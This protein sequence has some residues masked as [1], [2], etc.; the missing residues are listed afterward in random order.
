V[1]SVI[2]VPNIEKALEI[3][4][5][6]PY[7]NA[8]SVYTTS[9]DI[10]R[11]VMDGVEAGM[12]GVNVGVPVPREPFGFGGWNRSALGPGNIPGRGRYRV[13]AARAPR[14]ALAAG[15]GAQGGLAAA[16]PHRRRA[17]LGARLRGDAVVDRAADLRQGLDPRRRGCQRALKTMQVVGGLG[18]WLGEPKNSSLKRSRPSAPTVARPSQSA[19]FGT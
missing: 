9:G 14:P 15:R 18:P 10:A 7:G 1:L 17:R 8:S 19:S 5:A 13:L 12:C 11:R 16:R 4:N 2:R 3:E 6:N